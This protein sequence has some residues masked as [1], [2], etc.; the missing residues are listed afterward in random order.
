LSKKRAKKP[1]GHPSARQR[2][3]APRRPRKKI[4]R[5]ADRKRSATA[6]GGKLTQALIA[7]HFKVHERTVHAWMQRGCPATSLEAIAV[8]RGNN[9]QRPPTDRPFTDRTA[10]PS[11]GGVNGEGSLSSQ[12]LKVDILRGKIDARSRLLRHRERKGELVER[13]VAEREI[14]EVLLRVKERLIVC[15]DEFETSFPAETRPQNKA[16][17]E[18]YV[19]QLLMEIGRYK[20]LGK[21]AD[22]MLIDAAARMVRKAGSIDQFLAKVTGEELA[23]ALSDNA[24]V[25]LADEDD[26]ELSDGVVDETADAPLDEETD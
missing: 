13:R 2:K 6:A 19:R 10:A 26:A 15:P 7:K 8:W 16:D 24:P 3:P 23:P 4:A 11:D 25:S 1:V 20:L 21:S 17:F 5:A 12:K 14:A 9:L 22:E 18:E